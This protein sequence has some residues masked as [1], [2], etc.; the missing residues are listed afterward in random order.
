[1]TLQYVAVFAAANRANMSLCHS[2]TEV[3]Q[4]QQWK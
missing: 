2:E 3:V 1:M 4:V